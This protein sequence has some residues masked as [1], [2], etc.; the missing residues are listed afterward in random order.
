MIRTF[1]LVLALGFNIFACKANSD[2]NLN[3]AYVGDSSGGRMLLAVLWLFGDQ[4]FQGSSVRQRL[5]F[6]D[7]PVSPDDLSN[8]AA[9]NGDAD[10]LNDLEDDAALYHY[11]RAKESQLQR[12]ILKPLH[13]I[14]IDAPRFFFNSPSREAIVGSFGPSVQDPIAIARAVVAYQGAEDFLDLTQNQY[15]ILSNRLY[16]EIETAGEPCDIGNLAGNSVLIP[17]SKTDLP[18]EYGQSTQGFNL[19]APIV[20]AV[21]VGA[22]KL[23]GYEMGSY[24]YCR[25]TKNTC[26]NTSNWRRGAACIASAAGSV[27]A[28]CSGTGKQVRQAYQ[29]VRGGR[30]ASSN[31]QPKASPR[32][33][34]TGATRKITQS[35]F[36]LCIANNGGKACCTKYGVSCPQ[37]Q[38]DSSAAPRKKNDYLN[39]LNYNGGVAG[40]S[41]KH[42]VTENER[43]IWYQECI[44]NGGGA[45]GC[46]NKHRVSN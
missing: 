22:L 23:A 46:S 6:Y 14:S 38:A 41:E 25:A 43:T 4:D 26:N 45:T 17:E 19:V 2:S 44:A 21:A 30:P 13:N 40:C 28:M 35:P 1:C 11:F 8:F 34:R 18:A 33:T 36:Q 9:R 10:P 32:R 20:G 42:G 16:E 12:S 3:A 31:S 39:C 15:N 5:C 37:F 29:V 7:A 27:A 24:A